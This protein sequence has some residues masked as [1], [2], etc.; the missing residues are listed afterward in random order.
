MSQSLATE[1]RSPSSP[2]E[3]LPPP[4]GTL[5]VLT[6]YV[7]ILAGMWSAVYWIMLQRS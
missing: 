5:F 2:E 7:I 3:E 1:V 4:R 6:L